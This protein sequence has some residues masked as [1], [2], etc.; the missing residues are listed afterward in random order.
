[1]RVA[2]I[3][4]GLQVAPLPGPCRSATRSRSMIATSGQAATA[5]LIPM[6]CRRRARLRLWLKGARLVRRENGA[7]AN[8]AFNTVLA[9][10]KRHA[11]TDTA[12]PGAANRKRTGARENA[13]VQ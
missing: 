6:R 4:T 3:E 9:N 13:L 12:S 5:I 2:V 10:G 7:V 1:M 11:Y 8:P